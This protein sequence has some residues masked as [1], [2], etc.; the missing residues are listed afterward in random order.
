M[1]V[2]SG[3]WVLEVFVSCYVDGWKGG[4]GGI[5]CGIGCWVRT[6]MICG[7]LVT[8]I[9]GPWKKLG[10]AW[11]LFCPIKKIDGN[12]VGRTG[13]S[14]CA[15]VRGGPHFH[16][17]TYISSNTN[18]G[19]GIFLRGERCYALVFARSTGG[20][21]DWNLPSSSSSS[22]S[23]D[24]GYIPM[25]CGLHVM[26]CC[27][28]D[29]LRQLLFPLRF[30]VAIDIGRLVLKERFWTMSWNIDVK[31]KNSGENLPIY[32]CFKK[33]CTCTSMM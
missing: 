6:W 28:G 9:W 22:L 32:A 24:R 16:G 25:H 29:C 4:C 23:R 31:S 7:V 17:W 19:C 33:I 12:S 18:L 1:V 30:L 21:L 8:V 15:G 26:V 13:S 3:T 27:C 20:R 11:L 2:A 10:P 14:C 5:V